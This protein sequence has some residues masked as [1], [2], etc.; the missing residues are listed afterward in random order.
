M[1]ES[2]ADCGSR[3]PEMSDQPRKTESP[4][5]PV[6][7]IGNGTSRKG[8]NLHAIHTV[9]P[10]Y[11]CNALYREYIPDMLFAID[12]KMIK[13]IIDSKFPLKQ[14]AVPPYDEQFEPAE[15]NPARPRENTG[16]VAMKYAIKKGFN[17]LNCFGMDFLI[18]SPKLNMENIFDG[19]NC[20]DESTR[21]S[22]Q[23]CI[24]RTRYFDW[25]TDKHPDVEFVAVFPEDIIQ[26][27]NFRLA[28]KKNF[29]YSYI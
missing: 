15:F 23:D 22:V 24:N 20:Y 27:Q 19:T 25:F 4:I 9:M 8:F 6:A 10:I 14:F 3:C 11:G 7:I 17:Q 13:E 21:A 28:P 29:N 2:C 12:P 5:Y 16:M 26:T 1:T 18:D